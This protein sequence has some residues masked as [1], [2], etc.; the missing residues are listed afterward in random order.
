MMK[1][2]LQTK[3]KVGRPKYFV[4]FLWWRWQRNMRFLF[5]KV[6]DY[7]GDENYEND[8]RFLFPCCYVTTSGRIYYYNDLVG[9][10]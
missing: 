7:F 10:C 9:Y 2:D 8:D 5:S 1:S 3:Y 4:I 6:I